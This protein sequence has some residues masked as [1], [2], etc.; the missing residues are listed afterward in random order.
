MHC[1][2]TLSLVLE[3]VDEQST[4]MRSVMALRTVDRTW[5]ALIDRLLQGKM[6]DF[7]GRYMVAKRAG[8]VPGE[9]DPRL[10][11]KHMLPTM[12]ITQEALHANGFVI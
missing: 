8:A 6:E 10:L 4:S 12:A 2:D 5:C 3:H 1:A 9:F 7:L 11:F